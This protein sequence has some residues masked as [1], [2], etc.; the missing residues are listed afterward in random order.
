M[1]GLTIR[2]L[3]EVIGMNELVASRMMRGLEPATPP[4]PQISRRLLELPEKVLF[5]DDPR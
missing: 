3:A 4:I 1:R 2:Q 5:E